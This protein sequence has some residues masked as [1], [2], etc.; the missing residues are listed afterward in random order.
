M[1][2]TIPTNIVKGALQL[3]NTKDGRPAFSG[4]T[5]YHKIAYSFNGQ[6][7]FIYQLP[8]D[9]GLEILVPYEIFKQVASIKKDEVTFEILGDYQVKTY[10]D[11]NI[12]I[13]FEAGSNKQKVQLVYKPNT[14]DFSREGINKNIAPLISVN[15]LELI[16]KVQKAMS[17]KKAE[18]VNSHIQF[19]GDGQNTYC[20]FKNGTQMLFTQFNPSNYF[21]PIKIEIF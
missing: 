9:T 3:A 10:L 4:L 6:N 18:Y 16:S 12:P 14:V 17:S 1:I 5:I 11:G 2:I 20:S 15:S 7:L 21:E 8:F 13:T 19:Y